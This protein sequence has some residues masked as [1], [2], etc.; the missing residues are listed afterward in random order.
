MS[1]VVASRTG[2]RSIPWVKL[3]SNKLVMTARKPE[4]EIAWPA[5]P[6]VNDKSDAIGVSRLTGKNSDAT[7]AKAQS[8]IARTALQT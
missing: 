7:N 4:M 2:L 6:S 8:D 3:E 1:T 5:C